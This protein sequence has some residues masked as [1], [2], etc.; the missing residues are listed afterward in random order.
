MDDV[1]TTM[2]QTLEIEEEGIEL[3]EKSIELNEKHQAE[4]KAE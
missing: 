1:A 3:K 2:T 4:R